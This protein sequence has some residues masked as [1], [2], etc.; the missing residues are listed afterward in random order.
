M[1]A[2]RETISAEPAEHYATD[3]IAI[4]EIPRALIPNHVWTGILRQQLGATM[5][6]A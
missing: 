2:R 1:L 5:T 6:T 3:A 4:E